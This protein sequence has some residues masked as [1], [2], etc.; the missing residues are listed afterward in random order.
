MHRAITNR[1]WASLRATS[2][3]GLALAAF[4][5]GTHAESGT[6]THYAR[7]SINVRVVIPVVVRVKA[8]LQ[9]QS[10]PI[11]EAD[12]ARGYVD[13][14]DATSMRLTSNSLSGFSLS[15]AFDPKLV[16]RVIVRMQGLAVEAG[17]PGSWIHVEAPK[18]MDAPLRV[19]Y[20]LYLAPGAHE[21]TFAWPVSLAFGADA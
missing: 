13:L 2:L 15:V 1:T 11:R 4:A 14:D 7:A 9:P 6:G 19:G 8:L 12:V 10:L 16:S 20:R 3:L 21:G 5:A 17:A 18:M